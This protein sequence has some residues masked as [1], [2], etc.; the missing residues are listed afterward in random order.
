VTT[1]AGA[2]AAG[3]VRLRFADGRVKAEIERE[4]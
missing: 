2:V 1:A 4:S 3:E